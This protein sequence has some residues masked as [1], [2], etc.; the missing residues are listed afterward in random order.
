MT[1]LD[2]AVTWLVVIED[3]RVTVGMITVGGWVVT[4][5]QEDDDDH[6][7]DFMVTCKI[8]NFF[9]TAQW[10]C[11]HHTAWESPS[12][13]IILFL[14]ILGSVLRNINTRNEYLHFQAGNS[15]CSTLSPAATVH[16]LLHRSLFRTTHRSGTE[17]CTSRMYLQS[18]KAT[19]V[20]FRRSLHYRHVFCHD[21]RGSSSSLEDSHRHPALHSEE[22]MVMEYDYTTHTVLIDIELILYKCLQVSCSQGRVN[23]QWLSGFNQ[24]RP[25]RTK[26]SSWLSDMYHAAACCP[27]LMDNQPAKHCMTH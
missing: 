14:R 25:S 10:R 2:V 18:T 12:R 27:F 8:H 7:C 16:T 26:D 20:V 17:F 24:A 23:G 6:T 3:C 4:P 11:M 9:I 5:V 19:G 21:N 15:L 13:P 22:Q 1:V